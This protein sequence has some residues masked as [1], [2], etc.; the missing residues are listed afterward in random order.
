[1]SMLLEISASFFQFVGFRIVSSW[2]T[3]D[4]KEWNILRVCQQYSRK[5]EKFC[6]AHYES[7]LE[8]NKIYYIPVTSK[9]LNCIFD[10]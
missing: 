8:I 4:F 10:R 2:E 9:H 6:F 5:S 1:M 3:N 7:E